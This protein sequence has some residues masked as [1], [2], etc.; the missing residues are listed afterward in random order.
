MCIKDMDQVSHHGSMSGQIHFALLNNDF[1]SADNV[2]MAH[3]TIT[4]ANEK[5]WI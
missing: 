2:T 4:D 5:P 1:A 3:F